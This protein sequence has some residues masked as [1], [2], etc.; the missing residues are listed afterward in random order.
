MRAHSD[1]RD[2]CVDGLRLTDRWAALAAT[3]LA[4][5]AAGALVPRAPSEDPHPGPERTPVPW[6]AYPRW[7]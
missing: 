6:P 2:D 5:L 4:L 7:A 1:P 3:A